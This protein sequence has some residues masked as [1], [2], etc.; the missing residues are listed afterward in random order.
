MIMRNIRNGRMYE[1]INPPDAD[2]VCQVLGEES[3]QLLLMR[4]DELKDPFE[5]TAN[6]IGILLDEVAN[7]Q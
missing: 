1:V 7:K 4:Y 5:N 3:S 6:L 2:G